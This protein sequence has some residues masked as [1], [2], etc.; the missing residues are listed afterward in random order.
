MNEQLRYSNA[1]LKTAGM[2]GFPL[3]DLYRWWKNIPSTYTNWKAQSATEDQTI[4]DMLTNGVTG[5]EEEAVGIPL[6]C[7]L[8]QNYPNPFNPSTQISY[9]IPQNSHVTLKVFNVLGME[10][11]TLFSGVQDSGNHEVAFNASQLSSGVY[12]YRLQAGSVSIT[13]KMVFMK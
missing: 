11:A 6:E 4:T 9:S 2:N 12:F 5:V 13:K 1:T 3:G 8:S 10:V 7:E